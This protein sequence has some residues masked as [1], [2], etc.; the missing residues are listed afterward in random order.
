MLPAATG[1]SPITARAS[2]VLPDP[3]SPTRATLW[4]RA[5]LSDTPITIGSRARAK[6]PP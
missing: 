3:L 5:T 2:V 1:W 4:P 6:K